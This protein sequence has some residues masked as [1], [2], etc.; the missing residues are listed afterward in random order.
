VSHDETGEPMLRVEDTGKGIGR[1]EL[2]RIFERF[3]RSAESRGSGLGLPIAREIVRA[4]GGRIEAES[5]PG[6]GT[7]MTVQLPRPG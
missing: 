5:R 4:H 1:E 7:T 3:Y 2:E 6:A